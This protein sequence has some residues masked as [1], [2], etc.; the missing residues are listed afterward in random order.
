MKTPKT[1][2]GAGADEP[3][4]I[5][6]VMARAGLCSR[7]DAEQWIA[8]GRVSV[9]GATLTSP[10][11]TVKPGDRVLV[12]GQPLPQRERTRLWLYHKP[13]GLVTTNRDEHGRPTVFEHLPEDLPRV[14]SVG[15]LD[16]NTEGLLLL[17]NDG[18]LAR[19]LELP[20]TGWLRRY[21]V[22]AHGEISQERL[23]ALRDGISIDGIL[24]G[25]IEATLDRRQGDNVWIT[26]GLREGKNREIKNILMHLGL[27]VNRLIRLSFGPFQLGEL[28]EGAVEEVPR[29]VLKDQL[30]AGIVSEAGADLKAREG[31]RAPK[32]PA[33][34]AVPEVAAEARAPRSRRPDAEQTRRRH[35][36]DVEHNA[37]ARRDVRSGRKTLS[38][39]APVRETGK[40]G[41]A[42][43]GQKTRGEVAAERK[44]KGRRDA[45]VE[46][47]PRR[48]E[49]EA[50]PARPSRPAPLR[51][52]SGES[53]FERRLRERFV[54]RE[55]DEIRE[56][57]EMVR[58]DR[59]KNRAEPAAGRTGKPAG[60][61]AGRFAGDL[62]ARST[63]DRATRSTGDRAAWA[64]GDRAARPSGTR[65][66][67]ATEAG[68]EAR[69]RSGERP[70]RGTAAVRD[71]ARGGPRSPRGAP[72]GDRSPRDARG[73]D[74]EPRPSQ[75]AERPDRVR[76]PERETGRR[77]RDEAPARRE[78]SETAPRDPATPARTRSPGPTGRDGGRPGF[79]PPGN[80]P[81]GR[82]PRNAGP[83]GPTGRGAGP[84]GGASKAGAPAG[85]PR[86]GT[87]AQGGRPG[88]PKGG[89]KDGPK[90]GPKGGPKSGGRGRDADRRR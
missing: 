49:E 84:K 24:Y 30:G 40:A 88:G 46:R 43:Q 58:R 61:G 28:A 6:K 44:A 3:E 4:R 51:A 87:T 38:V 77:S 13:R 57:E 86:A 21:R 9:N 12:D 36:A 90:G 80:G 5:A 74:G 55:T 37:E 85:A 53:R 35:E 79:A 31:D 33:R 2:K 22:R 52:P 15:R 23:D 69:S 66:A 47:R 8:D 48:G 14:M 62:V 27:D 16:I 10:A 32:M 63:G 64:T 59:Q 34:S 41:Q 45:L 72:A 56:L 67:R 11:V 17:T 73:R 42:A 18:G 26:M 25:A 54:R 82:G 78:R 71:E 81:S 75:G 68:P 60:A 1:S 89:P 65:A 20:K 19:V 83:G 76:R 29:R 50:A 70:A 7:R 39:R